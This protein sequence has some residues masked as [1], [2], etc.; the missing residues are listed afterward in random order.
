MEH[1]FA[2]SYIISPTND[3]R[4]SVNKTSLRGEKT[5]SLSLFLF[6]RRTVYD[7]KLTVEDD[8][9]DYRFALVALPSSPFD[10]LLVSL[11]WFAGVVVLER[12]I[13][14]SP[15]QSDIPIGKLKKQFF[16]AT[17]KGKAM[18]GKKK[19]KERKSSRIVPRSWNSSDKWWRFLRSTK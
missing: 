17:K 14:L 15:K 3:T 19:K 13:L 5:G 1:S 10:I 4:S 7:T 16:D 8:N 9:L 12:Y 6:Y 2:R 18:D 11:S